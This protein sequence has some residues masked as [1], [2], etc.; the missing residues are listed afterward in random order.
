MAFQSRGFLQEFV[1]SVSVLEG[2]QMLEMALL[3]QKVSL[4]QL[5]QD[6]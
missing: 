2:G 4:T 5:L 1:T 6:S 3:L